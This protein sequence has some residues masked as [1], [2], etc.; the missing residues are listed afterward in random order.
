MEIT[1]YTDDY[2]LRL[3]SKEYHNK[4]KTEQKFL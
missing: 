3:H 4:H 2:R 1:S